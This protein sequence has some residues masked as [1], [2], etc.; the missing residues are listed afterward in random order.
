[1]ENHDNF[2]ALAEN[3][4]DGI[5]VATGQGEHVYAN[6]KAAEITGY[7]VQEIL[8]A[9][10]QDLAHPDELKKLKERLRERLEGKP[11]PPRYE[12]AVMRKDGKKIPVEVTGA[13][14]L[15]RGQPAD[16]VIIRDIEDRKRGEERFRESERKYRKLMKNIR[17]GVYTL[18]R[19]GRFTFVNDVIVRRSKQTAEWFLGRSYLDVIRQKDRN[20]VRKNFEAVM[21][22]EEVFVYEL[23]YP[24]ASGDELWVE[25]NTTALRDDT[26]IIGLLG[27]SRDISDRKM[28][29]ECLEK[30]REELEARVKERTAELRQREQE[31]KIKTIALK[32]TNTA[33]N[34][35]LKKRAR[36]KRELEEKVLSN[37]KELIEP[38]LKK[39]KRVPLDPK[40]ETYLTILADNLKEILSP[41]SRRLSARYASLTPKEAQ[42]AELIR[43]GKN[44]RQIA[45]M[46]DSSIWTIQ[47]HRKNLRTKLGLK[48]RKDSLKYHLLT[49]TE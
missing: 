25:V 26:G 20:H 46:L 13:K 33:L 17:D 3:A 12:T 1:M 15:W 37:V 31:L 39:L 7:S 2:R 5:L 18:D 36:D 16:I 44:T 10:M 48:N 41:F 43:H 23:A 9:K 49:F 8:E 21:R 11:V 32:E 47:F 45:E 40:N 6:K 29:E 14:T 19:D 38:Y 35:L 34:I 28:A 42:V 22:G 4:N 27:I 24:T 30:A